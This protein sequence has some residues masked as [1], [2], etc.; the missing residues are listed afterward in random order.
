MEELLNQAHFLDRLTPDS[1][2][3]SSIKSC[4]V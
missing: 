2:R 4:W 1:S 3:F